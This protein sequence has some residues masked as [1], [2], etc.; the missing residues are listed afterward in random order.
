[1]VLEP[2]FT[3]DTLA[4]CMGIPSSKH[5]VRKHLNSE[6]DSIILPAR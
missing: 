3:G 2:S 5:I 4:S 6:F 1:M